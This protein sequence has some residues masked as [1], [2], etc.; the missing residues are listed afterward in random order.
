MPAKYS[1]MAPLRLAQVV[2]RDT[3]VVGRQCLA[4]GKHHAAIGIGAVDP[5]NEEHRGDAHSRATEP[6]HAINGAAGSS[7]GAE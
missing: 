6:D 5:W 3:A 1:S 2:A 7:T 4:D